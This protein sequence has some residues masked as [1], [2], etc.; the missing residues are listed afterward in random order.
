MGSKEDR[1]EFVEMVRKSCHFGKRLRELG[2]RPHGVVRIDSASSPENWEEDPVNN[3]KLIA[4]TFREACDVAAGYGEKLAAEGESAG[5]E[6]I[7][8]KRWLKHWRSWIVPTLV[9]RQTCRTRLYICWV[10][11]EQKTEFF[12]KTLNGAIAKRLQKV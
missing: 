1:T 3:T 4:Q 12:P 9:F 8:G 6:C 5:V 2:I 7:A 10:T 11:T